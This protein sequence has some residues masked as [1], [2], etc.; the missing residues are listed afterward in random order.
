MNEA[1]DVVVVGGGGSGLAAALEA[2][3][4]GRSVL[5]IEKM[6]YLLGTTG[7]S[8]GSVTATGTAL[9]KKAGI[10]DGPKGH[11]EDMGK[12]AE[13]AQP[14]AARTDNLELRKLLV[15]NVT[16]TVRQLAEMGVVFIG[17]MPEPPH[18]Q[19]RMHNIIPHSRSY[20]YHLARA[21]RKSGVQFRMN[22]RASSLVQANGRIT[23]VSCENGA[24]TATARYEVILAAGDYSSNA[25]LKHRFGGNEVA[26]VEGINPNSNGDGHLMGVAVGGEIVMG[27]VMLG[28]EIRFIAPQR[29][30]F[31]Q[32][33]P[34]LRF[35]RQCRMTACVFFAH[36]IPS[37][38]YDV[39]HNKHFA[40]SETI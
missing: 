22:C 8:I 16:E 19:P 13:L 15:D 5:V 7:R 17:P 4:L 30:N 37:V 1:F 18:T 6:P 20:V 12:F 39:R 31:V 24:F 33:M 21:C 2:R 3:R 35:F 38:L 36:W 27:Q 11:F 26:D 28:P 10:E 23:G 32:R 29:K 40:H 14:I 9:Q 25:E 34:P